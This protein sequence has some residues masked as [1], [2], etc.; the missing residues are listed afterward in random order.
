MNHWIKKRQLKDDQSLTA[1]DNRDPVRLV[2]EDLVDDT[3]LSMPILR[4]HYQDIQVDYAA[5][6]AEASKA[7]LEQK[8]RGW[9]K[10]S[11]FTDELLD[12]IDMMR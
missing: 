2:W 8:V 4:K 9:A 1:R 12:A 10:I 5:Y 3:I 11:G 6:L 7:S